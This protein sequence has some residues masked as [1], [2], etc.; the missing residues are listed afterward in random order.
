MSKRFNLFATLTTLTVVALVTSLASNAQAD[1]R[2]N[3]PVVYVTGQALFYDTIVLGELPPNGPFQL[4]EMDGPTG[5]LTQFGPGDPSYVG[6]RW[7]V[8]LNG[9]G[10]MDL[11]DMYFLCPLLPPGRAEP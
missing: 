7:W 10:E 9:D 3:G 11:A 6:G 2:G 4:L 1:G 8:D 5:L